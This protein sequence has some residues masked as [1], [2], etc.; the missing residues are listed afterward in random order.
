[1]STTDV[2]AF[3]SRKL[4]K[5]NA[6]PDNL[7]RAEL[8]RLRKGI[9]HEPGELPE[10]WGSFLLDMPDEFRGYNAASDEEWAIY[11]ALTYYALHQQGKDKIMNSDGKSLGRAVRE[12]VEL[13]TSPG[14]DWTESSILKRFNKLVTASEISEISH[15]LRGM[16]QLLRSAPNGGVSLDYP[17]LAADLYMLQCDD[18]Q[19]ENISSNVKL[20]WGQDLYRNIDNRTSETEEK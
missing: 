4:S 5:I 3:V 13:T 20:R 19:F 14:Q 15:H 11:I 10:L 9:G 1:M 17:Q 7:R 8:A 16:I 12:L 18:P 6:L 2:K